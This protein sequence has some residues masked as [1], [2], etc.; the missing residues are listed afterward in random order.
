MAGILVEVEANWDQSRE[1]A[2]A[3]LER[4]ATAWSPHTPELDWRTANEDDLRAHLAFCVIT[5]QTRVRPILEDAHPEVH[6]LAGFKGMTPEEIASELRRMKIRFPNEKSLRISGILFRDVQLKRLLASVE[7]SSDASLHGERRARDAFRAAVGTGI[8]MKIASLFL[9][10]VGFARWLAVLDSRNFRFAQEVGLIGGS[11]SPRILLSRQVYLRFEEWEGEVARALGVTT[12]DIDGP[13]MRASR[14]KPRDAAVRL[15]GETL[16]V[17]ERKWGREAW[18]YRIQV[19]S[20]GSP[21]TVNL[22]QMGKAGWELT[23]AVGVG[24]L[25]ATEEIWLFFKREVKT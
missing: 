4:G 6:R 19:V 15:G 14:G 9:K 3:K 12:A 25:G 1:A 11:W 18:E 13:I 16:T 5:Y 20:S 10:D 17:P 22:E 23:S 24:E 21:E 2:V 8:G 7:F